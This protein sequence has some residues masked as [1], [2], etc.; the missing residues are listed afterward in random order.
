EAPLLAVTVL[1]AKRAGAEGHAALL[2][3]LARAAG[4]RA[5]TVGGVA[6]LHRRVYGH[7]WSEV[8]LDGTWI[9]VDPTFGQVPASSP[10]LRVN[11]GGTSRAIDLVPVF[12]SAKLGP[13]PGPTD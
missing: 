9:A 2:V 7:A 13:T 12:G 5:R 1:K 8:W 4:I 10:L 3:A 6:L 11:V